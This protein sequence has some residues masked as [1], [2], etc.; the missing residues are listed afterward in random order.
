MSRA[1]ILIVEDEGIVANDLAMRL[2]RSGYD[3]VGTAASGESAIRLAGELQPNLV[4][5]DVTLQGSMDG[6]EAAGAI[7][8]QFGIPVVYLTAHSDQ[9]TL[10][11]AKITEPFGYI[12]KPFEDRELAV[13]LDM[14]LYKHATDRKVRESERWLATT[15][16]SIADAVVTIDRTRRITFMNPVAESITG[17]TISEAIGKDVGEICT[18]TDE[19]TGVPCLCLTA[20]SGIDTLAAISSNHAVLVSREGRRTPVEQIAAPIRDENGI[21][22]GAV[23]LF[24]DVTER[25]QAERELRASDV[26]FRT[27]FGH[28]PIGMAVLTPEGEFAD[29]NESFCTITGYSAEE[30]RQ[31]T[32]LDITHPDDLA[33]SR[34]HVGRLTRGEVAHI[35]LEKRYVRKDGHVVWAQMIASL[36]RN[37]SGAPLYFIAQLQDI[38]ARR[39]WETIQG[40]LYR[41]SQVAHEADTL[42][43]L[44]AAIHAIIGELMP[45]NNFYIALHDEAEDLIRFPYYRD[46][47]DA[48]NSPQRPGKT[49][50]A[51]VLRTSR[52]LL[53]P[54]DVFTELVRAGEVELVG[55][56]SI[57]WL[58]VPLIKHGKTFGVLVLQS[59]TEGV[60][61]G[62]EER[63]ILEYVSAQ[64]AMAIETKQA[65]D[66][67]RRS[68]ATMKAIFN[69]TEDLVILTDTSGTIVTTN[70]TW[71]RLLNLPVDSLIARNMFDLMPAHLRESRRVHFDSVIGL[72]QAARW[73]DENSGT[74]WDNCLYPVVN[75]SGRVTAVAMFARDI[76]ERNRAEQQ[77]AQR[78]EELLH[79]KSTAEEQARMV[80]RQADELRAAREEALAAS[81]LKSEFVANVSHEIRTPMN[82]IIGMTGLLLDTPLTP[83]QRESADIIRTSGEALLSLISTILDFSKIEAGKLTLE[84]TD[85]DLITT[86]EEVVD[87]FSAQAHEKR[88]E[89]AFSLDAG[90]PVA[91]HGDPGRL[92]QILVNLVGNAIKFTDKGHVTIRAD[93]EEQSYSDALLRFRVADSGIGISE[94]G[95]SRLFRSFSQA[96][97]ST[98]RKYGGTGLGLAISRQLA[99]MMGGAIGVEST[100]GSGSTFWFTIRLRK[101]RHPAPVPS[102]GEVIRRVRVLVV[103]D[104]AVAASHLSLALAWWGITDVSIT[105]HAGAM[106]E[107]ER[108]CAAG[109]RYDVVMIDCPIDDDQG[110]ELAGSIRSDQRMSSTRIF[111]MSAFGRSPVRNRAAF[112]MMGWVSKPIRHYPLANEFARVL[113]GKA[114]GWGQADAAHVDLADGQPSSEKLPANLRVL[115]AEDNPINQ[116]VA[117]EMLKKLGCRADVVGNGLEAVEAVRR[118]AYDIVLMDCSMPELDGFG[119]TAAIRAEE[120]SGRHCV[121]VAMTAS[122]LDG[123]R[124]R[125]LASGMDDYL[126]KPVRPHELREKLQ[127]W[128]RKLSDAGKVVRR[129]PQLF[130]VREDVLDRSRLADL[131]ALSDGEDP[132]WITSLVQQFIQDARL[133]A[134]SVSYR[135]EVGDTS[136]AGKA[137]HTLKGSSGNMGLIRLSRVCGLLQMECGGN[138]LPEAR[139]LVVELHRELDVAIEELASIYPLQQDTAA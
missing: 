26:R 119:A 106:K 68:E 55:A 109:R 71:P 24:R 120:M 93:V 30:L 134:E 132:S 107:I 94:E 34:E 70:G 99:E 38:S 23:V 12:L 47:I 91:V 72:N 4:L 96:D 89:L 86:V 60:R 37:E 110:L 10:Q 27:A 40:A 64:V 77:L 22:S 51:H 17:W 8:S 49:L 53:A 105:T 16:R 121:I 18:V 90:C 44:Y 31:K 124:E 102:L 115:L 54:P 78:A 69:V 66:G 100:P 62:D 111:L 80:E 76:T 128:V 9:T 63:R 43:I 57:D 103:D 114:G 113:G 61:Y 127:E 131:S 116:K 59:Y 123:D 92:R 15:L 73:V 52:S 19:E 1:K 87:L 136:G 133:H 11:R 50:T 20:E 5:M 129:E 138:R 6:V 13:N 33:V 42:D 118:I 74:Y 79:A 14:A 45:A 3:V 35:E 130:I 65:E 108:A 88:L 117:L 97:G 84:Q 104:N 75:E 46:E 28:T 41:I 101:Q 112:P 135:L 39:R 139:A 25:K 85:F 126:S 58:G 56:P 36:V 21:V 98:T 81:Q 137:A 32:F 82:A 125:C 7:R 83:E 95:R 48:D 67:V 2:R 29:V 122:A